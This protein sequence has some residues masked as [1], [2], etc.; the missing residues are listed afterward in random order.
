MSAAYEIPVAVPS[1]DRDAPT[2]GEA[3]PP[4][5]RHV[6]L[7]R[8][9]A[10][11]LIVMLHSMP[12][13][14]WST[15]PVAEAMIEAGLRQSSMLFFFI[16]GFLFQHLSARYDYRRYLKRK[17]EV[18]LLPYLFVSIPALVVSVALV[19]QEGM[20]PWFYDLPVWRQVL[21]F[22]ITGK[23]LEPLW[24]VPTIA[25]FY[26]VSPAFIAID[27]SQRGYML[28]PALLLLAALIGPNGPTGPLQKALYLLPAYMFGMFVSRYRDTIETL[29]RKYAWAIMLVLLF[30]WV[31]IAATLDHEG[32]LDPYLGFKLLSCPLILLVLKRC[33]DRLPRGLGTIAGLS[34][35]IY[36]IHGYLIAGFRL[37]YTEAQGSHWHGASALFAP[38]LVGVV[39]HAALVLAVSVAVVMAVQRLFPRHSRRIVGA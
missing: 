33:Q 14:D 2:A 16:S 28:L 19:R 20:W 8:G 29:T 9:I 23:H 38:S 18:I 30:Q 36:F 1:A 17:V 25:L 7:F 5:E 27:R 26:I 22:L 39:V 21:L 3:R 13:F 15:R 12:S 32:A 37:L 24:F 6:H 10:I 35:G 4:F 11:I 31:E 34:F